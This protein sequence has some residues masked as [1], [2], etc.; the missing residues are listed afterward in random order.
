MTSERPKPFKTSLCNCSSSCCL[1]PSVY[2]YCAVAEAV[3]LLEGR[4]LK[5]QTGPTSSGRVLPSAGLPFMFYNPLCVHLDIAMLLGS[6]SSVVDRQSCKLK[7]AG[8]MCTQAPCCTRLYLKASRIHLCLDNLA[9]KWAKKEPPKS[10][11]RKAENSRDVPQQPKA[12]ARKRKGA[13]NK[14]KEQLGRS[15]VAVKRDHNHK[16]QLERP[17]FKDLGPSCGQ[18]DHQGE[19][20]TADI[21]RKKIGPL[22]G[23]PVKTDHQRE[24]EE[25]T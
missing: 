19:G 12:S 25:P 3:L 10:R 4:S 9:G 15:R 17:V 11:S 1:L 8:S 20:S 23:S 18:T 5:R 14:T 22:T 7:L 13:A 6:Y 2:C 24:K 16:E 21:T